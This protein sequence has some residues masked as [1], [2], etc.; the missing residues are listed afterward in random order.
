MVLG[1]PPGPAVFVFQRDLIETRCHLVGH[2][3][4][5]GIGLARIEGPGKGG[6]FQ[7]VARIM[8]RE[9]IEHA[10]E[11]ARAFDHAGQIGAG[12][13]LAD[14]QAQH[15]A[16]DAHFD[17]VVLKRGLILEVDLGL[18][19]R[20]LVKRRLGDVEIAALDQRRHLAEEEGQQQRADMRAVDIGVGHDDDLVIAQFR[21]VEFVAPDAGA[22]AR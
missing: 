17:K 3:L 12:D 8:R 5:I 4:Q 1:D 21:E 10:A 20:D 16:V 6:L 9:G 14:R 15:R 7:D 18:A 22:Q 11:L 13:L 2:R 19:A